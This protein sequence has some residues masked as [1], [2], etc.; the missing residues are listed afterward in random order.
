MAS[1]ACWTPLELVRWTTDYFRARALPSPRLDA[2]L[3]LAHVME[4]TRLDLYL[5]FDRPVPAEPRA[6]YREL[7]KRRVDERVPVAYLTGRREFWSLSF[8][9]TPAVLIPRPETETLV[10]VALDLAAKRM[11]EVGT[12]SGCVAAAIASER[13]DVQIVALDSSPEALAIAGENLELHDLSSRVELRQATDLT[14]ID[15]EFDAVISNPPYIPTRE[16]GELA[17]EVQCEPEMALDG[18]PDGLSLVRQLIRDAPERLARPGWLALEVGAGQARSVEK[19][20][21][22][23]GASTV[24]IHEDLAGIERVVAAQFG[25]GG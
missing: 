1:E 14:G 19:L 21:W 6:R 5:G 15:S 2:E 10:R 25:E 20:L 11:L 16:L 18:G 17:P 3:L 9:V 12:G 4:R 24:D 22:E 8:R 13:P 23:R 7:V